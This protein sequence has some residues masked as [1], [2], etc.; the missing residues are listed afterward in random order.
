VL[1]L[2]RVPEPIEE[3]G[4]LPSLDKLAH[5]AL[6]FAVARSWLALALPRRPAAVVAVVAA[7]ALYGGALELVQSLVGRRNEALDLA[8]DALGAALAPI[9]F[10][11]RPPADR[12]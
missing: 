1:L 6:F 8:A 5:V 3:L 11:P 12:L 9:G 2:A 4:G 10:R 7:A